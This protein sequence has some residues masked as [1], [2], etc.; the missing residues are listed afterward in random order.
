MYPSAHTMAIGS[1]VDDPAIDH[2][3]FGPHSICAVEYR[4]SNG[5]NVKQRTTL[6]VAANLIVWPEQ[7]DSK[8]KTEVNAEV[9]S[10]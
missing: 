5:N 3:L 7:R 9:L 2:V 6:L 10:L 8:Y 1:T 4:S